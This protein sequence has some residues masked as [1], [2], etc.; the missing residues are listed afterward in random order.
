L[1]GGFLDLFF[2]FNGFGL[3]DPVFEFLDLGRLD[4]SGAVFCPES[5]ITAGTVL[6]G[7]SD[8]LDGFGFDINF[9]NCAQ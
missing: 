6:F 1:E 7:L 3:S 2:G 8:W 4:P 9:E 5:Y